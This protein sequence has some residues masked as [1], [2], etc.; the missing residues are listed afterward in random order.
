[1]VTDD[2][3]LTYVE[4]R[5]Q[6]RAAARLLNVASSDLIERIDALKSER[7]KLISQLA[8]LKEAGDVS[9]EGLLEQAIEVNGAIVVIAEAKGANSGLMRQLI[10]QIRKKVE[11]SAVLLLAA[12]G[13][14][15]VV[16]VAGISRELVGQGA[17]AGNWVREVAPI[18]GGGG[19]GKPDMAQAGGKDAS[20]IPAAID[21]AQSIITDMLA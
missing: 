12:Q 6:I 5:S 4:K 17:N 14:E 3:S 9:A 8:Q 2:V 1:M 20:Q 16:L 13:P 11:P 10:D 19:G 18:V 21:K 7:E 15:K